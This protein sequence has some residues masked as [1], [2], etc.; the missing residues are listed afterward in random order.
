MFPLTRCSPEI[1]SQN[2]AKPLI[3]KQ[4]EGL[5]GGGEVGMVMARL[6]KQCMHIMRSGAHCGSPAMRQA[7]FCYYHNRQHD[8]RLAL[9]A[10]RGSDGSSRGRGRPRHKGFELRSKWT[11]EG[12]CPHLTIQEAGSSR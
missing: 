4:R 12:G 8:E 2:P 3:A 11:A 1:K 7:R 10:S 9:E 6:P 5:G